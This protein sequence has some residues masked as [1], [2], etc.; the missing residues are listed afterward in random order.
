MSVCSFVLKLDGKDCLN[1]KFRDWCI[2]GLGIEKK[3]LNLEEELKFN[4]MENSVRK[5]FKV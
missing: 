4:Q 5:L 3:F 1:L 2:Y